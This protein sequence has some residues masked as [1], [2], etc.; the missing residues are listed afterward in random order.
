MKKTM[1]LV[2]LAILLLPLTG[3]D[4]DDD[5]YSLGKF[6]ITTATIETGSVNPYVIVTDNGD[7]LFPSATVIPWFE[8]RDQQRVWISYSILGDAIGD[9]DYYVK[10]NDMSEI[11]TKGILELTPENA[12]FIGDDP[13]RVKSYWITGDFLTIDF[14]YSGGNAIHFI[15]LVQD[16]NNPVDEEGR[17]ILLFRHNRNDDPANYRMRGT[18]SFN[19]FDLRVDGESFVPFVLRSTPFDGED[20]VD[21]VLVY[22]YD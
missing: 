14:L 19:L 6:W 18:V 5:C 16:V 1:L 3:C 13:L 4:D 21:V 15:N 22:N 12:D 9:F 20:P 10:V 11:L 2:L 8:L 17:P 7:R